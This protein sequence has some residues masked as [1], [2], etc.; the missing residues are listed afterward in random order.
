MS[1]SAAAAAAES[2]PP[3]KQTRCAALPGE[4][5]SSSGAAF[6]SESPCHLNQK[7]V[8]LKAAQAQ[9]LE[10]RKRLKKDLRN[11][12]HKRKRIKERARQLTDK[13][14]LAVLMICK[15]QRRDPTARDSMSAASMTPTGSRPSA[16]EDAATS[17][18]S[19]HGHAELMDAGAFMVTFVF[20]AC[21]MCSIGVRT[22]KCRGVCLC[23]VLNCSA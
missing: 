15:E 8:E 10:D 4:P 23:S 1:S 6:P 18:G 22:A 13:N 7:I 5:A 19:V 21:A 12:E 3:R 16:E 17:A 9:M 2:A 14:L 11:A 20:C